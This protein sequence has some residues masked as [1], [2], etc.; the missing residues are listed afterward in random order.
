MRCKP[1]LAHYYL[2][3]TR[4]ETEDHIEERRSEMRG[5]SETKQSHH[6]SPQI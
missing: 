1:G 5:E 3:T 2:T 4:E 6:S